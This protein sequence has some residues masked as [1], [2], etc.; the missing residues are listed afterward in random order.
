MATTLV[1]PPAALVRDPICGMQFNPAGAVA[2][3]TVGGETYYFCAAHCVAEFDRHKAFSGGASTRG[4]PAAPE[5]VVGT[6]V[7]TSGPSGP[8]TGASLRPWIMPVLCLAA[9]A[10]AAAVTVF[11]VSLSTVFV[12]AMVLLCPLSHL[13]M[14]GGHGHGGQASPVQHQPGGRPGGNGTGSRSCH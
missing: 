3:R 14:M 2:T 9:L 6:D 4:L 12:A 10:A 13:L 7:D 5:T 8:G 1:T 11:G